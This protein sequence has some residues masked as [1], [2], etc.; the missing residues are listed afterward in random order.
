MAYHSAL[1]DELKISKELDRHAQDGNVVFAWDITLGVHA[2]FRQ[3]DAIY[4]EPSWRDGYAKFMRRAG[5]QHGEFRE[6]LVAISET[7]SALSVPAY[8]V[9]GKHMVRTLRPPITMPVRVHGYSAVVGLWNGACLSIGD[10]DTNDLVKIVC[11]KHETILDFCCGYG[12]VAKY[13]RRFICSD[14]N[15]KC[16]YYVAKTFMGYN[17]E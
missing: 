7:I 15:P 16:V 6:Y 17:D 14:V 1:K 9:I 11:E 10:Y 8:I 3:A 13:A 4:S 12:N 2:S 5:Q